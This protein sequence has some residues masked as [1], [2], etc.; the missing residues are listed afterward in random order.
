MGVFTSRSFKSFGWTSAL[1]LPYDRTD[2][3]HVTYRCWTQMK[4]MWPLSASSLRIEFPELLVAIGF[5][6]AS[7]SRE[8]LDIELSRSE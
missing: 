3:L 2:F 6:K 4:I 1:N 8:E 5:P 7:R